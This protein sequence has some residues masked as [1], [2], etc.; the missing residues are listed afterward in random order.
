MHRIFKFALPALTIGL[1]TACP[2]PTDPVDPSDKTPP[3]ITSSQPAHDSS[4]VPINSKVVVTFSEAMRV[5]S[6]QVT[7]QPSAVLGVATWNAART[8]V[9]Y[10]PTATFTAKTAYT[11]TVLGQDDAG[12]PLGGRTTVRFETSDSTSSD[13]TPPTITSS[14]PVS[15]ST[16]VDLKRSGAMTVTFSEAMNTETLQANVRV[17]CRYPLPNCSSDKLGVTLEKAANAL[18]VRVD[19]SFTE[20]TYTFDIAGTDLAGNALQSTLLTFVTEKDTVAPT[21]TLQPANGA[22]GVDRSATL[23]VSFSEPMQ[24]DSL[25]NGGIQLV[26]EDPIIGVVRP[27]ATNLGFNLSKQSN[28]E[29]YVLR[30][31][32]PLPYG[33]RI[34]LRVTNAAKDL[35][36]NAATPASSTVN[37]MSLFVNYPVYIIDTMDGHVTRT[38]SGDDF[39]TCSFNTNSTGKEVFIGHGYTGSNFSNTRGFVGFNLFELRNFSNVKIVDAKLSIGGLR[40]S[41]NPFSTLGNLFIERVRFGDRLSNAA[42]DTATLGCVGQSVCL[43]SFS[44]APERD[45]LV[46]VTRFVQQD[47][48]EGD[49]SQYRLR[50]QNEPQTA[51]AFQTYSAYENRPDNF[52]FWPVL[53]VTF[54]TPDTLN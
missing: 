47:F 39:Q 7:S 12:N 4:A 20:A 6:V 44:S 5:S 38:C 30:P 41:G 2:G 14:D 51:N 21:A 23:S 18:T 26:L 45:N 29:T 11:L 42:Y 48:A 46:N 15:G 27:L 40:Q 49:L 34:T 10:T 22:V 28:A 13:T 3:T 50:F 19:K 52:L 31:N 24:F 33:S 35:S 8:S 1:L 25:A 32:E 54:E 53:Y 17:A 9:T 37:T 16:D 43:E 36:D